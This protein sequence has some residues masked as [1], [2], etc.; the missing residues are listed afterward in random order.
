MMVLPSCLLPWKSFCGI[1]MCNGHFVTMRWEA[2]KRKADMQ[3][4]AEQK[5]SMGL[6][7]WTVPTTWRPPASGFSYY[8]RINSLVLWGTVSWFSLTLRQKPSWW[9]CH[10]RSPGLGGS[11]RRGSRRELFRTLSSKMSHSS[12]IKPRP[13]K[14]DRHAQKLDRNCKEMTEREQMWEDV[15]N[16]NVAELFVLTKISQI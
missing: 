14:H 9:L 7:H 16:L 1:R 3:R 4:M 12:C 13:Y 5:G 8:Y 11:H 6:G 15:L 2:Q 10:R